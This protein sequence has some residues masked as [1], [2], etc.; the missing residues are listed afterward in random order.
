MISFLLFLSPKIPWKEQPCEKIKI[1]CFLPV[2]GGEVLEV[3]GAG[4]VVLGAG[5]GLADTP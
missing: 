3:G 2:G 1:N 5:G 4:E